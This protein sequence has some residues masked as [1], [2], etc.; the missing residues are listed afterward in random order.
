MQYTTGNGFTFTYD[1]CDQ[2]I[3]DQY[4][5]HGRLY[6]KKGLIYILAGAYLPHGRQTKVALHRLITGAPK[7]KVVDHIDG[8][9]LN[10]TRANLRVC[11]HWQNMC[12]RGP[13][14]NSKTGI[15]GVVVRNGKF[16]A[17]ITRR[18]V[19]IHL[20]DFTTAIEAAKAYDAA[21][22]SVHGGFGRPNL[23]MGRRAS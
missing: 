8:N 1:A 23:S 18:R 10:N 4:A 17:R 16:R 20:G 21:V 15:K 6:P 19:K 13:Q 5:W 7:G 3:V 14:R 2:H 9:G 12:N 22:G 11:E